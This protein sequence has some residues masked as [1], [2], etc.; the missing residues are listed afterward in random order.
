M[1]RNGDD[2]SWKPDA[3]PVVSQRCIRR[4]EAARLLAVSLR[5]VDKLAASGIPEKV[6][7][8]GENKVMWI[9]RKVMCWR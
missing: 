4:D 1:L 9:S 7:A 3:P 6:K 5:T 2:D 8:T